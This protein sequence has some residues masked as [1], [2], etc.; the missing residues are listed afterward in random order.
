MSGSHMDSVRDAGRYD[1]LFGILTA[2]ACVRDLSA[3]GKRLPY[4]FEVVAFGDEEGVRFGVTLSGSKAMGGSFEPSWL[5]AKDA[6]G[7]T[8]RDAL[9]A[10]GGDPKAGARSTARRHVVAYVESHIEQGR[11]C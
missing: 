10:F 1:G 6:D 8:L 2:I 11:C 3:R 9:T 4:T 5:D 7:T